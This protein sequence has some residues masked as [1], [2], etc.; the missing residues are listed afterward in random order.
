MI[1]RLHGEVVEIDGDSIVLDVNGVGYDVAC[2]SALLSRLSLNTRATLSVYTDVREDAI[3]LFGF[4]SVAERH[5][6]LL[7]NRVSGM[8]PRSSLDVVS[9]VAIRDLLRA[10]GSGD[11]RA[12][13]SIK[14]VGKKKA[15]RIVV[16]LRDLVVNM[17]GERADSLRAMVSVE[18]SADSSGPALSYDA[19]SALE[20][21]GFAKRDAE[22]AV[23]QALKGRGSVA[24]VGEL[25]REALRYV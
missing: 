13:M 22:S 25:I 9:N 17:A 5:I 12:L 4:D 3:R 18:R 15:E 8:G 11:V 21:L 2:T 23:S 20:V 7:L 1:S 19:V 14:G 16:E 24:D 10:I 6:F